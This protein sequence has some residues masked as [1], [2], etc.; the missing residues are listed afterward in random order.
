[1]TKVLEFH[2]IPSL[3]QDLYLG[4]T[5][6]A[7]FNLLPSSMQVSE[8]VSDSHNLT[9]GQQCSLSKVIGTFPSFASS[10]LGKTTFIS[11]EID[12]GD[13]K[14]IKQCHFPVLPA[15]EKLLC[16]EIDRMLEMGVIEKSQSA[17]SLPLALVQKPGKVR[18]CLE[19]RKV[20]AATK[21]DAYPLPQIDGILSR[22]PK[23]MYISSLDLKDAY[24]Q[25][26]LEPS[27]RDKTA[28]TIPG[29]PLYQCTRRLMPFGLTKASQTMTR[30]MDK[31]IPPDLRNEVFVYLDDLLVVSDTFETHMK[32]L[33]AVAKQ[34]KIAGL[35]LNVEKSKGMQSVRY[36]RHIVGKGAIRTDLEKIS[37]MA[38]FPH[39]KNLR[40]LRSFL[41]MVGW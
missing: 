1:V 24:W 29:K 25:I 3:N 35:T 11:Y 28:F 2:I 39:P 37:A 41:G 27:S 26:P 4:I 36:L 23:A 33:S 19:S 6:W 7:V 40:F 14:P 22:L 10:G 13:A 8:M 17:W 12:V 18:L 15:I 5:F 34:I 32:D 20:N 16:K 31:V 9:E 38:D 30:L 21:K